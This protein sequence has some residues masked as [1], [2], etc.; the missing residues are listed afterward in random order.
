MTTEEKYKKVQEYWEEIGLVKTSW[1]S[2]SAQDPNIPFSEFDTTYITT[3]YFKD[4]S[5]K[6]YERTERV[7]DKFQFAHEILTDWGYVLK[8]VKQSLKKGI[9]SDGCYY[10]HS[11]WKL[12]SLTFEY[13][14]FHKEMFRIAGVFAYSETWTTLKSKEEI[15]NFIDKCMYWQIEKSGDCQLIREIKLRKLFEEK[16]IPHELI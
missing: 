9:G 12:G 15:K 1:G 3:D 2:K 8:E 10:Q 6:V 4:G 16:I 5:E 13:N 11:N 14:R 7:S